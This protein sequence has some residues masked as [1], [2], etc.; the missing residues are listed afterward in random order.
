LQS[1]A[2]GRARNRPVVLLKACAA[3]KRH[4]CRDGVG[5]IGDRA[6]G[7][8][9]AAAG[10]HHRRLRLLHRLRLKDRILDVEIPAVEGRPRVWVADARR[11]ITVYTLFQACALNR[12]GTLLHPPD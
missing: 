5:Q 9:F 4:G 2:A 3:E 11:F 12:S 10:D 1:S 6:Q 8:L 7:H